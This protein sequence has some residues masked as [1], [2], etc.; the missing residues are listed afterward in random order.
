MT[1]RIRR[2]RRV[3]IF[4]TAA[5]FFTIPCLAENAQQYYEQGLKAYQDGKWELAI[6][7][8]KAASSLDLKSAKTH[9]AL[10]LAYRWLGTGNKDQQKKQAHCGLAVEA[11][12]KS[13]SLNPQYDRAYSDMGEAYDCLG[14]KEKA[15]QSYERAISV[16]PKLKF[17]YYSL[18]LLYK[19][20]NEITKAKQLVRQGDLQPEEPKDDIEEGWYNQYLDYLKWK[21]LGPA[22]Q[23]LRQ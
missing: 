15:I 21:S 11:F 3:M 23:E 14:D 12:K 7:N 8:W 16:N 20:R 17:T 6:Q 18:A 10:G 4:C 9:R 22:L 2:V 1:D 19:Q 13:V 5:I